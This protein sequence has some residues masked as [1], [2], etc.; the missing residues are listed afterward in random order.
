MQ[1]YLGEIWVDM[2][3]TFWKKEYSKKLKTVLVT[4]ETEQI[5]RNKLIAH[6]DK[7]KKEMR[8]LETS[9]IKVECVI[10]PTI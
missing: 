9:K 2:P 5:A 4:A 8:L 10:I 6:T 7:F 1:Y 3:A